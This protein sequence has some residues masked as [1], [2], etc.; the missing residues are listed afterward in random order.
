MLKKVD[1]T[2]TKEQFLKIATAQLYSIVYYS[3]PVWL[4]AT[5]KYHGSN[6]KPYT[7]VFI[8]QQ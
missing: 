2:L 6:W 3:A 1:K 5:L 7:T 4:N 8:E